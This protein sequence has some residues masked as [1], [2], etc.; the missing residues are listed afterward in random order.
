MDIQPI[1]V[2]ALLVAACGGDGIAEDPPDVEPPDAVHPVT[3]H[4]PESL[5]SIP[6]GRVGV[7]G[8]PIGIPCA[9][10]HDDGPRQ[11]LGIDAPLDGNPHGGLDFDHGDTRCASCHDPGSYTK[12]HLADGRRFPMTEAI[13]LCAQCHGPQ[14]RDYRNGS[15]G[16]MRGYWDL[17][18][19]PRERNHCVDC[20]DPHRPAFPE[21]R[22]APPPRDRFLHSHGEEPAHD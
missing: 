9:T 21:W 5:T 8:R 16:G 6:S 20:H 12:L 18:R 19:G 14:A 22:P 15:H 3:I 1:L 11:D 7:D 13:R 10:C 4:H 2:A 17:S